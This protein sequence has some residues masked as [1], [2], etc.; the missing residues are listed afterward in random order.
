MSRILTSTSVIVLIVRAPSD[1]ILW[2]K[3]IPMN[4]SS[5]LIM[6]AS[7]HFE[8]YLL[9]SSWVS[10]DHFLNKNETWKGRSLWS[11]CIPFIF[12]LILLSKIFDRIF[13]YL[14]HGFVLSV[15]YHSSIFN[16][17]DKIFVVNYL[18]HL[19]C[20]QMLDLNLNDISLLSKLYSIKVLIPL[21]VSIRT[22][23]TLPEWWWEVSCTACRRP[24]P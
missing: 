21:L 19:K 5:N 20:I 1:I 18:F 24:F 15:I 13:E 4:G 16:Y 6:T 7:T 9:S 8:G 22:G 2:S 23:R 14:V 17:F 12:S 10:D 11:R 3:R